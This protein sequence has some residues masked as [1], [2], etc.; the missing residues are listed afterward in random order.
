MEGIYE[1]KFVEELFDNMSGSYSRINY[2]T[3]FGFSER[4]RRQCVEELNIQKGAII[5]DLMTG[6]G[7]CWTY[8]LKKDHAVKKLIALDFSKEMIKQANQ[9]KLTYKK[10]QIEVR[11]ENVFENGIKN[12]AADYIVSGFG[13]KT[14]NERQL[15]KLAFEIDRILMRNGQFSLI[16]V[17][18]PQNKLLKI[19]YMFY[20]K[21]IIPIFGKLLLGNPETYKMLGIYTEAYQNSK[22]VLKI[23][24]A[25]GFEV[26]YVNYFYGCA[27]G[28]KGRKK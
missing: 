5:V 23:F 27:S 12:E 17:S 3:S 11:K 28:I 15:K 22:N 8:I 20:L 7:E 1:S 13:L 19:G 16:D 9:N 18:V 10:Q 26:E 6:M 14:F 4:W 2:I 21:N 24:K 25:Q